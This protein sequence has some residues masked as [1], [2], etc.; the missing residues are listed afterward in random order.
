MGWARPG[1]GPKPKNFAAKRIKMGAHG[2]KKTILR[3]W[4]VVNRLGTAL[5][6]TI[7]N[8]ISYKNNAKTT[9][10]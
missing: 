4:L 7:Y 9:Y 1:W 10:K 6:P 5:F 2:L 3:N 8:N